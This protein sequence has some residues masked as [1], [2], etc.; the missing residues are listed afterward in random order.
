[1]I[2]PD[3][4]GSWRAQKRVERF[5]ATYSEAL[6]GARLKTLGQRVLDAML[7]GEWMT[8]REIVDVTGGSEAGVSARLREIG[9]WARSCA[10]GD[11]ERRRAPGLAHKG[12]WQYR[13]IRKE[14]AQ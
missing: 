8:L 4:F 9:D 2:E 1:M 12:L 6:D 7:P 5:G 14:S 3:L 11:M 13:L 10:F